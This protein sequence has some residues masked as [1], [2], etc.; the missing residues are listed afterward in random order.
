MAVRLLPKEPR[1]SL[2][3][4]NFVYFLFLIPV[5]I[6]GCGLF[7]QM[8]SGVIIVVGSRQITLDELERD[9]KS[10]SNGL[11]IP[12]QQ[13][14]QIRDQF[15]EQIIDR[16]LVIE[17]GKKNAI[18]ISGRE[19]SSALEEL[20]GGYTESAFEDMLLRE[21]VDLEQ[22]KNRL[23]EQLLVNKIRRIV[24]GGIVPP[25]YQDIMQ[26]FEE[27]RNEFRF[28]QMLEFR[29]IVT[30]TRKEAENLLKRLHNGE[31]MADLARKHSIAPEAKEVVR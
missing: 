7:D 18:S 26:Y 29:Q 14:G 15:V 20:K 13:W 31:K 10:I 25:S 5:L 30:R 19:L 8:E 16:C 9:M 3:I 24:T 23:R 21:Y 28:P 27:N 6:V 4:D 1:I 11:D 2:L 12:Y 22:W 17:Y